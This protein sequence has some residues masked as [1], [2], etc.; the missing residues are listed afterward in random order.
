M[1]PALKQGP[2]FLMNIETFKKKYDKFLEFILFIM[3]IALAAVVIMGVSF[4]WAGSALVWYDEVAAVQLA[5][6]I[7][8]GSA[9]ALSLI[10]I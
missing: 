8:Y 2:V 6:L 7:Y 4:R 1:E 3:M 5:W 9:Y 10:H